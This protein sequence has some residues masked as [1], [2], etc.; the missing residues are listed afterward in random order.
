MP[1]WSTTL[2]VIFSAFGLGLFWYSVRCLDSTI[3]R[4]GVSLIWYAITTLVRFSFLTNI[5]FVGPFVAAL[6]VL[7]ALCLGMQFAVLSLL[8]K[9]KRMSWFT[10][11]ALA[12]FWTFFEF[13]RLIVFDG[14]AFGPLGLAYAS[15]PITAQLASVVGVYGL[16]FLFVLTNAFFYFFLIKKNK[17]TMVVWVSTA[18]IPLIFGF[19]QMKYHE[20][21]Q[22]SRNEAPVNVGLVQPRLTPFQKNPWFFRRG[23]FIPLSDQLDQL[24]SLISPVKKGLHYLVFPE[25]VIA[26]PAS[27]GLYNIDFACQLLQKHFGTDFRKYFPELVY[28]FAEKIGQEMLVSNAFIFQAIA[29]YYGAEV[30]SSFEW[31]E[32]YSNKPYIASVHF[33]PKENRV[34][35]QYKR[36]LFPFAETLPS[37]FL[38]KIGRKFGAVDGFARGEKINLFEGYKNVFSSICYEEFFSHLVRKGRMKGADLFVNLSND[39]WYHPSRLPLLHYYHARLR[40]VENGVDLLRASNTGV[41]SVISSLGV[42]LARFNGTISESQFGKGVLQTSFVPYS[43]ETIYAKL[44]DVPLFVFSFLFSLGYLF[45]LLRQR[46]FLKTLASEV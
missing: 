27:K 2:S 17:S 13:S 23:E 5:T 30:I 29:N 35:T 15:F 11:I 12:S 41:T 37:G 18:C 28:P 34:Q 42:S 25:T 19:S 31:N 3:V 38:G 46:K 33:K 10:C 16:S 36:V 32:R 44:G 20:V 45:F 21:K 1:H 14:F 43:F 6:Y 7:I 39:G 24:L 4:G 26:Y 8:A 9:P 22:S 40:A